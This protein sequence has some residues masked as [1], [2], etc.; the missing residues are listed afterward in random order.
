MTSL[1]SFPRNR[2]SIGSST[3]GESSNLVARRGGRGQGRDSYTGR[4]SACSGG[5]GHP[6]CSYCKRMGHTKD[7][8]YNLIGSLDK[9]A[10]VAYSQSLE[11]E[12][13]ETKTQQNIFFRCLI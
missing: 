12:Q 9:S 2:I 7:T 1:D 4:E 5:G 10:A 3:G 6:Q 11:S 13:L 8:C